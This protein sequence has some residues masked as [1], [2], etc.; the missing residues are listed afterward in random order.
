LAAV[1]VTVTSASLQAAQPVKN[2]S[3]RKPD[4][5]LRQMADYLTK[6]PAFGCKIVATLEV[7]A[8][9][10]DINQACKM[11]AR[12]HRPNRLALVLDEGVMGM[13]VGGDGNP[14]IQGMPPLKR[15]VVGEV[16]VSYAE[17]TN[18]GLPLQITVLGSTGSLIPQGSGADYFKQLS[19]NVQSSEY[20]GL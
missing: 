18:I 17:M 4:E 15:Y 19:A 1:V 6:L 9:G 14:L 7:K 13:P 20:V 2:G 12:L 3:K 16:P 8:E 11:T 5:V 10:H